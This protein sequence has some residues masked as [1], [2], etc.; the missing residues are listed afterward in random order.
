MP[1]FKGFKQAFGKKKSGDK[2]KEPAKEV[3]DVDPRAKQFKDVADALKDYVRRFPAS[4]DMQV[5]DSRAQDIKQEL[6]RGGFAVVTQV[7]QRGQAEGHDVA[8]RIVP[9]KFVLTGPTIV[10]R[11]GPA[12]RRGLTA[13]SV[14]RAA[15]EGEAGLGAQH[16]QGRKQPISAQVRRYS[17]GLVPK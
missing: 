5:A 14:H 9:L 16:A 13:Q 4:T 10:R 8:M 17:Q 1:A 6:G 3:N 11:P 7:H 2:D 15:I 12:P